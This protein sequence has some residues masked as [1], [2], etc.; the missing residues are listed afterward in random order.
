M[1]KPSPSNR[2]SNLTP[3]HTDTTLRS[4]AVKTEVQR[5]SWTWEFELFGNLSE[6]ILP[7]FESKKKRQDELW[8]STCFEAFVELSEGGYLEFNF[9]PSGNWNCYHFTNYR[10]NMRQF[11]E[12]ELL[13]FK[14]SC[15]PTAPDH[16]SCRISVQIEL[17]LVITKMGMTSVIKNHNGEINYWALKHSGEK[18]D[19]H[20]SQDWLFS[21]DAT[22]DSL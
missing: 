18:A 2:S 20:R 12:V 13:E 17:P 6:I 7:S 16:Y 15:L 19:F 1:T 21:F 5:Q 22:S 14:A 4:I 10:E 9:S 8:K 3:Y 11:S